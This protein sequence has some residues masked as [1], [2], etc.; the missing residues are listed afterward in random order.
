MDTSSKKEKEL[1]GVDNSVVIVEGEGWVG[2][3]EVQGG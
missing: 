1:V 2:M 3:E